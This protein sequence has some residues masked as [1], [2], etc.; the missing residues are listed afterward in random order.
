MIIKVKVHSIIVEADVGALLE[1]EAEAAEMT[2]EVEV[3]TDNQ[4]V[5]PDVSNAE[6]RDTFH[7]NAQLA[8]M[9]ANLEAEV[10]LNVARKVIS[11]ENVPKVAAIDVSNVKKKVI[12]PEIVLKEAVEIVSIATNLDIYQE[13]ALIKRKCNVTIVMVRATFPE[14]VLKLLK[15]VVEVDVVAVVVEDVEVAEVLPHEVAKLVCLLTLE[16][17]EPVL[18]KRCHLTI[19]P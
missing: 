19:K 13:I 14:N 3:V 15:V 1:V 2:E 6:K 11:P 9:I 10:V 18:T 8:E 12:F 16:R 5:A 17:Q 4:E 7:V